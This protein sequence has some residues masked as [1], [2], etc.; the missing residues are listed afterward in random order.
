MNFE[1]TAPT[2]PF[3]YQEAEMSGDKKKKIRGFTLIELMIVVVIIGILAALALPRFM[4]SSTKSK[5]SEAKQYLKE[6][7]TMQRTY[8]MDSE[9]YAC[10]GA[11]ADS[12]NTLAFVNICVEIM[13][14]ARYTYSMTAS[15]NQFTCIATAN[16][17]D[18]PAIDTWVIDDTGRLRNTINDVS[19]Q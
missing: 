1:G 8:L 4:T 16:L 13:L 18:D 2:V 11:V 12:T 9:T 7:Y 6:I 10:N 14:P 15:R 5:Q 3:F 19:Q 17:D